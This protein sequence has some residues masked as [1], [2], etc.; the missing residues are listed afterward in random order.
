MVFGKLGKAALILVETIQLRKAIP[1]PVVRLSTLGI[2]NNPFLGSE[3]A[4]K[5]KLIPNHA[6]QLKAE[7]HNSKRSL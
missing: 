7:Q 5:L 1:K 6:A 4:G 3:Q 2:R